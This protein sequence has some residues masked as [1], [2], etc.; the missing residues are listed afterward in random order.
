MKTQIIRL[1]THDDYISIRDKMTWSKA[2]RILLVIP[3]RRPPV[4]QRLDLIL[5]QRQAQAL[6]S[7]V[8]VVTQEKNF[9]A[10]AQELGIPVFPTIPAAQRIGWQSGLRRRRLLR[11]RKKQKTDPQTLRK[12]LKEA[13]PGPEKAWLRLISFLLGVV[14][15]SGLM[16]FFLPSASIGLKPYREEQS[17]EMRIRASP[18]IEVV[19][20]SG[21]LPAE[22]YKVT[23]R[24]S[25]SEDASGMQLVGDKK[26][27]GTVNLINLTDEAVFIP[28]GT[29]IRTFSEPVI[30]YETTQNVTLPAG[31]GQSREVNVRAVAAGSQGNV[32][33]G[34]LGTVEGSLGLVVAVENPQAIF[35]GSERQARIVSEADAMRVYDTLITS[36]AEDARQEMQKIL[37]HGKALLPETL[38]INRLIEKVYQP[39]PGELADRFVLDLQ[40]EFEAWAYDRAHLER[41]L[42]DAM[43]ANL[44]EDM[45]E[46]EGS[47]QYRNKG[48]IS[49]REGEAVEFMVE[50]NRLVKAK[51]EAAQITAAI[52]GL[53]LE[54]A[55]ELVNQQFR[56]AASPE[57]LIQPAW[58][59]R[60]PFLTFR[61]V[62]EER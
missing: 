14:S 62:V 12:L 7:Q 37:P 1:E 33:A 22:V 13:H 38:T 36:L 23:V 30:R 45:T 34:T 44:P 39:A 8:G 49:F 10:E 5:I 18:Q 21:L 2:R 50:A 4:L 27:S 6:G 3:R 52:R 54:N 25:L 17:I 51:I 16:L 48:K 61:M 15:F 42:S 19:S 43:N 56:L 32:A 20:P 24:G 53:P 9:I 47:L 29:I 35:G 28:Q 11:L 26:A 59:R 46:V 58:W 57:I 41:V 60:L 40:V 55:F 31:H